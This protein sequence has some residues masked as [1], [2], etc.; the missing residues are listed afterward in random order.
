MDRKKRKMPNKQ[1]GRGEL[2]KLM[3][4]TR[5]SSPDKQAV[6]G[7]SSVDPPTSTLVFSATSAFSAFL[8]VPNLL[9]QRVTH[10]L[11]MSALL[12]TSLG[13]IVIDLLVDESPKACEK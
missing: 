7:P 5:V 12:E 3:S 13:D 2:E 11:S 1:S 6:I 10:N 9:I 8:F 4:C